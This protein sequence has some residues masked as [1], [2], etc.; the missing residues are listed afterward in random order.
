GTNPTDIPGVMLLQQSNNSPSPGLPAQ[1]SAFELQ[2]SSVPEP[3]TVALFGV[4]GLGLLLLKKRRT[5]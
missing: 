2:V 3:A 5:V 4:A 1:A